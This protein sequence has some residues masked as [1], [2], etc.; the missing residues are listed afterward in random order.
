VNRLFGALVLLAA[1]PA[2]AQDTG[3]ELR[4]RLDERDALIQQMRRQID[5][6]S[7]RVETLEERAAGARSAAPPAALPQESRRS[8]QPEPTD[9]TARALERELVRRGALVLPR[10]VIEI[11]P[12][13][14]YTYREPATASRRDTFSSALTL[15]YGLPWTL[16]AEARVPY[17][18]TDH[19]EGFDRTRGIGDIELAL[20]KQLFAEDRWIPGLLVSGRWITST[21]DNAFGS[22]RLP[23]GTGADGLQAAIAA[24]KTH[25][26]LVLFGR[27]SYTTYVSPDGI[28]WGDAI[29]L[30]LGTVLA[31]SPETSLF[32]DVD[33]TS[34]SAARINGRQIRE[35]DRVSAVFEAGVGTIIGR[36]TLLNI[37]G[38]IG[39]TD[40]APDLRLLVSLPTRF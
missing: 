28:D 18:I 35:T 5:A 39:I 17:V 13:V 1:A 36:D 38:A 9:E 24:V 37:T 10:G 4:R 25:D 19:Q 33:V 6:L 15:R 29:G 22:R 40:A 12:E 26:P 30:R 20:T 21:G 23:T 2:A 16:Q 14:S 11:E 3:E 8:I 32:F 27:A 34:N 7:H 31:A